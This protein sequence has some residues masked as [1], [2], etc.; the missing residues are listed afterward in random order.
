MSDDKPI[1]IPWNHRPDRMREATHEE[2]EI[3]EKALGHPFA[4]L[5]VPVEG[6]PTQMRD[7]K[8]VNSETLMINIEIGGHVT[9]TLES[10]PPLQSA[11]VRY[12]MRSQLPKWTKECRWPAGTFDGEI[13]KMAQNSGPTLADSA[14]KFTD[15]PYRSDVTLAEVIADSVAVQR[16]LNERLRLYEEQYQAL[17]RENERLRSEGE[18]RP[19]ATAP[20]S[21]RALICGGIRNCV[22]GYHDV[23]AAWIDGL[24]NVW[25]DDRKEGAAPITPTYWMP[26]LLVPSQ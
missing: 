5:R 17:K 9:V 26:L 18:W 2:R 19:I 15:H 6:I 23:Q 22:D 25:A 7:G 13:S 1:P 16:R 4:S 12:L 20:K 11:A 3:I 14:T 21:C 24:G 10:D 8:L